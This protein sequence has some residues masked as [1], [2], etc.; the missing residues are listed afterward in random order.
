[1][2]LK[3]YISKLVLSSLYDDNEDDVDGV[4]VMYLNC[5]H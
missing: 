5:G 4:S 3:M 1:V 2:Y